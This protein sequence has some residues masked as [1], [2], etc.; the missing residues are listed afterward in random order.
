VIAFV[1]KTFKYID[2]SIVSSLDKYPLSKL[3]KEMIVLKGINAA[4]DFT[5][6]ETAPFTPSYYYDEI[7]G[8][9]DATGS[10]HHHHYYHHY[11]Y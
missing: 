9:A 10:Y 3:M 8:I 7:K 6:K 4:L 11:H 1:T 5:I 2:D